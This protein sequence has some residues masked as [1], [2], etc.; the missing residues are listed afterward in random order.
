M[1]KSKAELQNEISKLITEYEKENG[2]EF[3]DC[4]L[5]EYSCIDDKGVV[6]KKKIVELKTEE[7]QLP[8][9]F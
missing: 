5:A 4:V 2:V 1:K 7:D 3:V 8:H 6:T 9:I